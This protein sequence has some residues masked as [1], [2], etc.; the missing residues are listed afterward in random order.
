MFRSIFS[1]VSNA[2]SKIKKLTEKLD[3]F[4][5][6]MESLTL[7]VLGIG[8]IV[9]TVCIALYI[10]S[11]LFA[12]IV[13]SV[14]SCAGGSILAVVQVKRAREEIKTFKD[15]ITQQ[16]EQLQRA[17][18]DKRKLEERLRQQQRQFKII[19]E[20]QARKVE[21]LLREREQLDQE[22]ERLLEQKARLEAMRINVNA[23][24]PVLRLGLCELDMHTYDVKEERI[25]KVERPFP[26][27]RRSEETW[28]LGIVE[29]EFKANF[30]VDLTK[31]RFTELESGELEIS[32]LESEFQGIDPVRQKPRLAEIRTYYKAETGDVIPRDGITVVS[33]NKISGNNTYDE[34]LQKQI[35]EFLGR[36][37][38]GLAFQDLDQYVVRLAM[39]F[40]RVIFAPMGKEIKFVEKVNESG[41]GFLEYLGRKNRQLEEQIRKI[42]QELQAKESALRLL[43]LSHESEDSVTMD[44][45]T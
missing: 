40:L 4:L 21:G 6:E 1:L 37:R 19:L 27:P 33:S 28:Y 41:L 5:K 3:R 15:T 29:H 43:N 20:E 35:T 17:E 39:E 23:Y 25:A 31:V 36:L 2:W 45:D 14:G 34:H 13:T 44:S 16:A 30:G 22:R 10:P 42:Q 18:E 24:R 38:Q 26:D 32:G 11:K 9:G 12:V 7:T 8:V